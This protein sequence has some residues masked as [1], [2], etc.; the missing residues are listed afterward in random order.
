[1]SRRLGGEALPALEAGGPRTAP[2]VARRVSGCGVLYFGLPCEASSTACWAVATSPISSSCAPSWR[3]ST[4]SRPTTRRLTD[5]QIRAEMA[6]VRAG[7]RAKLPR[8]RAVRGGGRQPRQ[9]ASGGPAPAARAGRREARMQ[10]AL[11]E[12]LPDVFAAARE[13]SRRKLGMR[14]FD[15]QLMGGIVL[16]Q[17]KIAE[18]KTGEG[19]TLVAPLA[20]ALNAM[21]GLGRPRRHRQRLPGQARPAMDGSHLPRPGPLGRHRPARHGL[22]LRPRVP[23]QRREAHAPSPGAPRA[24]PTRRT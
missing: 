18:M 9:R 1:M 15:V 19:K 17:G 2:T 16:H 24:R 3:A 4:T 21:S 12:V 10:Q 11:D 13:V 20:A 23:A 8:H 5:E 22:P 7:G 6:D 14:P